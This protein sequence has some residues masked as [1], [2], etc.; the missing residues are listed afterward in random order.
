MGVVLTQHDNMYTTPFN[1]IVIDTC[2]TDS[3]T[4]NVEMIE[5]VRTCTEDERLRILTNVGSKDHD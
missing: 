5:N 3:V 2:S 1:C 4:N